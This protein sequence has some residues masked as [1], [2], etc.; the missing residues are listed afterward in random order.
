MRKALTTLVRVRSWQLKETRR[1]L[2]EAARAREQIEGQARALAAEIEAEQACARSCPL[3]TGATY[4]AYAE[5]ACGRRQRLA[6]A[7]ARAEDEERALRAEL[8]AAFGELKRVE[9]FARNCVERDAAN[10]RARDGARLDEIAVGGY[11]RRKPD[12]DRG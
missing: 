4:A 9:L 5:A 11:V 6:E 7:R 12:A 2:V 8:E 1:R 10:A 3:E